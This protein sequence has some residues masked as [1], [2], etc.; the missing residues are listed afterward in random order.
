MISC[1]STDNSLTLR[2]SVATLILYVYVSN[3]KKN[4]ISQL[5]TPGEFDTL[6]ERVQDEIDVIGARVYSH[7][8]HAKDLA[9][10]RPEPSGN[11]DVASSK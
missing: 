7:E 4:Y 11:L 9:S 6:V 2:R 1:D 8:A 5:L 10:C 3:K